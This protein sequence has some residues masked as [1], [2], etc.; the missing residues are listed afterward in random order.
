MKKYKVFLVATVMMVLVLGAT[1]IAQGKELEEKPL[2]I[3]PIPRVPIVVDGVKMASKEITKFNGQILYYLVDAEAKA[4]G[5]IYI[6]TT[7]EGIEGYI[8]GVQNAE[9]SHSVPILSHCNTG[10]QTSKFYAST[11]YVTFLEDLGPGESMNFTGSLNNEISSV[12]ATYCNEYTKLYDDYNLGGSSLW[13]ACCG[14][15]ADLSVYGWNNRASSGK[16]THYGS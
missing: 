5:V 6:F 14:N 1:S 10:S 9:Y 8:E 12:K 2:N 3:H 13:L 7:L 15:T 16:V 11:N 4:K